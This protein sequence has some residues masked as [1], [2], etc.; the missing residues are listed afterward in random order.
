VYGICLRLLGDADRAT[1]AAQ[2][3]FVRAWQR[4]SQ[5]REGTSYG[6]WIAAIATTVSLNQIRSD[7]RRVG[8]LLF[9]AV[10]DEPIASPQRSPDLGLDL[11]QGIALLPSAARVVFTLHDV[12]GYA[13]HEIAQM[14]GIAAATVRVHIHK[15]RKLLRAHLAQ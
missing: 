9:A 4:A 7:S 8:Q 10:E 14:L 11:E 15:A 3:T 13:T 12:E 5:F 6:A 1:D 2:A